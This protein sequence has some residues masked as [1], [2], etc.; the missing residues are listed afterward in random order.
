MNTGKQKIYIRADGN[1]QIGVGHQMR[2]L[3]V[4][5]VFCQQGRTVIFL[6]ADE[7]GAVL[8]KSRG[9]ECIVLDSD[10][11]EPEQEILKVQNILRQQEEGKPLLL[12]DSYFIRKS[13]LEALRDDAFLVYFDD[14]GKEAWPADCIINYNIYGPDMPYDRLYPQSPLLL[15]GSAY[16][17]LRQEFADTEHIAKKQVTDVLITTGGAD[18]YNVAGQLAERLAGGQAVPEEEHIR[19]HVISG[20][21]HTFRDELHRLAAKY[22]NIMIHENVTQMAQLMAECDIAVSAAGSTLYELCAV[23]VPVVSFYF[24]DNQFLPARYFAERTRMLVCGNYAAQPEKTLQ[25]LYEGVRLLERE[26]AVRNAVAE[27]LENVT[28]GKGAERIAAC[29]SERFLRDN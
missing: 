2:C 20:V 10:Y 7:S 25:S 12:L 24:V 17:P 22:P 16:A 9:Y 27:S 3:S 14:Y 23:K 29:L 1:S 19:Y 15:L 18:A 4:A 11:R 5:D 13:Y 21:F 6:T 8:P 26:E 28:D